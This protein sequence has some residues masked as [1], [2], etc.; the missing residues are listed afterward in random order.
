MAI[1]R[2]N[3]KEARQ[4]AASH[5]DFAKLDATTEE[6]IRRQ[7][8]ED[9]EDSDAPFAGLA[10]RGAVAPATIRKRTGLSQEAFA[11]AL[12]IPVNTLRNWEQGRTLPD[13]SAQSLL[14]L[15]EHDHEWA[16]RALANK[17]A[18]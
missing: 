1:V 10:L 17:P 5:V 12:R 16:F 3:L 8:I 6:D 14:R 2:R 7:M 11:A 13:P 4:E 9:G 15:V 18:A